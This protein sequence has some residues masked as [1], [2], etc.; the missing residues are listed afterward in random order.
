M[1]CII[2]SQSKLT[3]MKKTLSSNLSRRHFIARTGAALVLPLI[4]PG[5]ATGPASRPR[6]SNRINLGVVGWGMQGPGNTK[7][8][9]FEEDCQ[10]VAAC[11]LDTNHL[12]SA[13]D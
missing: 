12:Q 7:S 13:V 1:L 10:V 3:R 11:D 8:F 2:S 4:L 9:L 5:C 6:P